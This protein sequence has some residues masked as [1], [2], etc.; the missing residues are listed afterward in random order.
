MQAGVLERDRGMGD[1]RR[2]HPTLL[3]GEA[4]PG[5]RDRAEALP[6]GGQR[7][8]EPLAAIR[9]RARLDDLAAEADYEAAGRAGRLDHRLDDHA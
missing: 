4:A 1:E 9:E 5:E 8:L 6:A 7:K 2:R 3:D